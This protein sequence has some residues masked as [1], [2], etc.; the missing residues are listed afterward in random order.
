MEKNLGNQM[1]FPSENLDDL[2]SITNVKE[3]DTEALH[4]SHLDQ[5]KNLSLSFYN[6]ISV[7]YSQTSTNFTR[8][9]TNSQQNI[10]NLEK[11][12][13]IIGKIAAGSQKAA[14]KTQKTQKNAN[15]SSNFKKTTM[16]FNTFFLNNRFN[17][18]NTSQNAKNKEN[19]LSQSRKKA[20]IGNFSQIS[21]K[22]APSFL[23]NKEFSKKIVN[24]VTISLL[25]DQGNTRNNQEKSQKSRKDSSIKS[26]DSK[27]GRESLEKSKKNP[28]NLGKLRLFAGKIQGNL[29]KTP[30][31]QNL[32]KK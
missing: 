10:K 19:S 4:S 24:N 32:K 1:L 7:Y 26:Q 16:N 18:G 9:S 30:K 29:E 21:L 23:K 31:I 2:Q 12:R 15:N 13:G 3:I 6:D 27:K 28:I 8:K 5:F 17:C 11:S 20:L 14:E 25:K 22:K